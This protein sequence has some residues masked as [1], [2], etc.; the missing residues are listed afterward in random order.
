MAYVNG[1]QDKGERRPPKRA[2]HVSPPV[3]G[4]NPFAQWNLALKASRNF[5]STIGPRLRV[6][7]FYI[8]HRGTTMN[9]DQ[10][11]QETEALKRRC[12]KLEAAVTAIL[13]ALGHVPK[14]AE[15]VDLQRILDKLHED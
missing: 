14:V 9:E 12:A 7:P 11:S 6:N 2:R 10:L 15:A 3:K 1:T 8:P 13:A 5:Q 4:R